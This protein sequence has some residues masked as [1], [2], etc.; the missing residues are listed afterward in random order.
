MVQLD[1]FP[2]EEDDHLWGQ[3]VD[4]KSS[5]DKVRKRLFAEIG[6]LKDQIAQ[7]KE[8]HAKLQQQ[9]KRNSVF[10]WI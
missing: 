5:H 8:E 2:F 6:D 10:T 7:L 3:L 9:Q 4:L 1:L